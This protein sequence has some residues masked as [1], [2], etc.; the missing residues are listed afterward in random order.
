[1]DKL[2]L[3]KTWKDLYNPSA[4]EV[5]V[6]EVPAFNFLMIDGQGD[7]NTS[8]DY[9]AA[10]EALYALSY[11]LK[12]AVKRA[13]GADYAV[14]PLEG[15]WWA[16]GEAPFSPEDRSAWRW[17]AMILQPDVVNAR[18]VE[19]ALHQVSQ[20]S[21]MPALG[22]VRFEAYEE[23]LSVQ[24]LHLGPYAAEGPTIEKLHRFIAERG[25]ATNGKHH[26]IYLSDPRRTAPEKIKTII[27]QPIRQ[28]P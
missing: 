10:V 28:V 7:P 18:L 24:I 2:D 11:T 13:G 17:T 20:K 26:E 9:Q 22:K 8:A 19:E 1:M 4:Q 21:P 14:M 16:E 3:K 25:Y 6:V 27:R 12:F 5:S 15:L 23:G